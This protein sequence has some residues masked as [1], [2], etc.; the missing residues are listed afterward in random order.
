MIVLGTWTFE[1]V[2]GTAMILASG[3]YVW[4]AAEVTARHP[5]KTWPIQY[6]ASF[7]GGMAVLW[8]VILGPV[9]A[10]DDIF[11]WLHMV[12][13]VAILVLVG[14]L[15]LLGAPVL[16]ILR[17]SSR[18]IRRALIIPVLHS[19]VLGWLTRPAVGVVIFS[20]VLLGSHFTPFYNYALEH[21]VVHNY[22]EHPVYLAASLILFYPLLPVNPSPRPVPHGLRVAALFSIAVPM[23]VTGF[24]IYTSRSLLYPYYGDVGR[25][26]GPGPLLDQEIG[27]A[28]MWVGSM[29]IQPV[30]V[31]LAML[32]WLASERRLAQ[33]IDL[34]TM[35]RLSGAPPKGAAQ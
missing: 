11:L 28:I 27:G 10:Y 35:R 5:E 25:P 32:E 6:T 34:D 3:A 30:W 8:I 1:P 2:P 29:V 17:V 18:G 26:F 21:P 20:V 4:A 15:I 19:T 31:V 23:V 14:P 9:G 33:R 12:Q 22:V 7:M 16:L 24:F 13:H